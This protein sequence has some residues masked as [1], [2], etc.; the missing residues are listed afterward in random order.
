MVRAYATIA[1]GGVRP[2]VQSVEDLVDAKGRTLE[3]RRLQVERVL[4]AGTAFLATTLLEGVALRGTAAGVHAAGLEGPIAAKTGTSDEE[5]DLWF[6]GFTPDL[7]AVVWIGFDEPRSLGI[8]SSV[9]ALPIWRRLVGELS[10]GRVRGRFA[11][12]AG[13]TVAEVEPSTGLLALEDCP[14]RRSEYFLAGTEPMD[15]CP[16]IGVAAPVAD[17]DESPLVRRRF[18]EWLRGQL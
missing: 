7:V 11:P 16:S 17:G 18:L 8:P 13:V 1:S 12:P 4:D 3:R 15:T 6:V 5:H 14:E 2:V 10:G 9:G